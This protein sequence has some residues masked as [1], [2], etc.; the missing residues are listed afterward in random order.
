MQTVTQ[1]DQTIIDMTYRVESLDYLLVGLYVV[2]EC[3]ART[4]RLV[5]LFAVNGPTA[6][7]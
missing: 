5:L 7:R 6:L 2:T 4:L 1:S 3:I